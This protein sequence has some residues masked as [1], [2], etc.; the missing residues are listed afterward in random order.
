MKRLWV[1]VAVAV[2][3]ACAAARPD[4]H[5]AKMAAVIHEGWHHRVWL[6]YPLEKV[7]ADDEL[8]ADRKTDTVRLSLA[9]GE[10]EPF[11]LLLRGN[12]PLREVK[13]E[14]ADL[15]GPGEF[16]ARGVKLR[17]AP[18]CLWLCGRAG[19]HT[20]QGPH[21]LRDRHRTIS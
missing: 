19:R 11:I 9:Q 8:P 10:Y 17:V 7:K 13:V 5:A 16:F 2:T 21:A 18:R 20:H 3:S 4:S 14:F 1:C 12:V 6:L 15:K